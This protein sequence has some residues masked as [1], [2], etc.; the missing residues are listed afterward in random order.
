ML[1]SWLS[2]RWIFFVNVPIGIVAVVALGADSSHESS[3]PE[4][5]SVDPLGL[6]LLTGGLFCLVFALIEGNKRGW[7]S[8]F[9]VGA[10]RGRRPCCSS[11]SSSSSRGARS[12]CSTCGCSASPAFTG[13]Q[14]AAFTLSASLFAMFL[15]LT[16]YLQEVLGYSPLQAGRALPADHACS[17]SSSRR[18]RAS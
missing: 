13:A 2:W 17:R 9:I 8:A 3:D 14:I 7:S 15:Y 4:H 11:A 16:L 10:A 12:R 5:G 18:S 6:V 1:T